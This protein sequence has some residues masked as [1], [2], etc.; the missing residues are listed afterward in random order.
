VIILSSAIDVEGY[1]PCLGMDLCLSDASEDFSLPRGYN[2]KRSDMLMG[3]ELVDF[4]SRP[5]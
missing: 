2:D 5:P 3:I 4:T 1:S